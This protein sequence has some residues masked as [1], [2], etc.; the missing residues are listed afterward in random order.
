[1]KI[2]YQI[3]YKKFEA[4]LFFFRSGNFKAIDEGSSQAIESGTYPFLL[5]FPISRTYFLIWCKS[6]K[7]YHIEHALKFRPKVRG[8]NSIIDPGEWII[9]S[10]IN[11]RGV[12]AYIGRTS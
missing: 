6:E 12:Q 4:I 3:K 7:I 8:S 11:R 10:G 2:E 1:M 9:Y 5:S